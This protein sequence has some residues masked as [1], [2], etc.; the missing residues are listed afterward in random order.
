VLSVSPSSTTGSWLSKIGLVLTYVTIPLQLNPE[1]D[2]T[3]IRLC[4]AFDSLINV[5]N[6]GIVYVSPSTVELRAI[7]GYG[8]LNSN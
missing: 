7:S 5:E 1:R 2:R 3:R 6:S 4:F 8:E